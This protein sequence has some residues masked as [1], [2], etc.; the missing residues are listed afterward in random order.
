MTQQGSISR[1][2]PQH[3]PSYARRKRP[4]T[5]HGLHLWAMG[6]SP[7]VKEQAKHFQPTVQ[8]TVVGTAPPTQG[9]FG[10]FLT[11]QLWRL[12]SLHLSPFVLCR[13]HVSS[14]LP[15]EADLLTPIP[16]SSHILHWPQIHR[17]IHHRI[18]ECPL[19]LCPVL[20]PTSQKLCY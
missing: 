9:S 2:Q 17:C 10:L 4:L 16:T 8:S 13:W 3:F 6:I 7:E 20:Y 15:S 5:S 14:L 11:G 18:C 19:N 12:L 1:N